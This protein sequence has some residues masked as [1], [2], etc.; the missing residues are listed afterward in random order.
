M[1]G[2]V[3]SAIRCVLAPATHSNHIRRGSDVFILQTRKLRF[4]EGKFNKADGEKIR[5]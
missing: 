2:P 5:T 3:L 4:K 1:P